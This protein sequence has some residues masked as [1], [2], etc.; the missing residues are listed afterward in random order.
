MTFQTLT[1]LTV[2]N[3]FFAGSFNKLRRQFIPCSFVNVPVSRLVSLTMFLDIVRLARHVLL[4]RATSVP[5][6]LHLPRFGEEVL[7][8]H[9]AAIL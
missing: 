9:V 2:S 6:S 1:A 4:N 8:L 7:S 5:F 3:F